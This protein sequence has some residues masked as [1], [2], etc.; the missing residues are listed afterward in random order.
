M[1]NK[2]VVPIKRL[3][4][5]TG[6][7]LVETIVVSSAFLIV[8]LLWGPLLG[9]YVDIKHKSVQAARYQ[10]W[11]ASVWRIDGKYDNDDLRG[12]DG[13]VST[14][15][16]SI[17]ALENET[18]LRFYTDR[19]TFNSR[20]D[21]TKTWAAS[22]TP[23]F[24]RDHSFNTRP[25]MLKQQANA[26]VGGSGSAY[27]NLPAGTI[28]G[29]VV[30]GID[31]LAT[32]VSSLLNAVGV[33]AGFTVMNADGNFTSAPVVRVKEPNDYMLK[34]NRVKGSVG[35]LG[36]AMTSQAGLTTN[37]W[38]AAGKTHMQT[39]SKGLVVNALFDNP[40]VNTMKKIIGFILPEVDKLDF[41]FV[42]FDA[43]HPDRVEGLDGEV[44]CIE[45]GG[46]CT[47][48]MSYQ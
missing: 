34:E 31:T 39:Q 23:E 24:W 43:I 30:S 14:P 15:V 19:E 21:D 48:V 8:I 25:L 44:G 12:K 22:Q 1:M 16:K 10:T 18:M 29:G 40:I 9:K 27:G 28:I 32:G 33:D 13:S 42:D 37:T 45:K 26:T 47:G 7:A 41:G 35:P 5:C 3:P 20:N 46:T 2:M 36:I 4:K 6:Q 38:S 17:T 11:E